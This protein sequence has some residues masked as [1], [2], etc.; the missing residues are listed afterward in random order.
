MASVKVAPKAP[1]AFE[2][3]PSKL[4]DDSFS[5]YLALVRE[6][7]PPELGNSTPERLSCRI[8]LGARRTFDGE[9]EIF[10][11]EKY[12]SGVMDSDA[13]PQ[14]PENG[15]EK[16]TKKEMR[17]RVRSRSRT[18]SISSE[19][20]SNSRSTL[21]RDR[22]KHPVPGRQREAEGK[23]FLG[24]FPC[25]CARKNAIDVDKEALSHARSDS[26]RKQVAQAG[27]RRDEHLVSDSRLK[28][29]GPGLRRQVFASGEARKGGGAPRVV[30]AADFFD[31]ASTHRR[32]LKIASGGEGGQDD[33]VQSEASSD[34]FEIESL[35]VTSSHPFITHEGTESVTT[36]TYEPSEASVDW[37]VVM[38]SVANF[39]I[40]SEPAAPAASLRK[41]RRS[42]GSGLLLGCVSEK[43]V[44]VTSGAKK[45]TEGTSFVHWERPGIDGAARF[46]AES[47]GVDVGSGSTG[48]VLPPSP[49]G[50]SRSSH[51]P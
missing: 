11:A 4:R 15:P 26:L 10:D 39:S 32:T 29:V 36:T 12:F 17:V 19:M 3:S 25:S 46:R 48:R 5:T 13:P 40:A 34:L 43:A 7:F 37:S 35:S 20:T 45:T 27:D 31:A 6:N 9:I 28:R 30:F 41:T 18:G 33:D 24:V 49:F 23:R 22:R 38:R 51:D 50:S 47:C 8:S 42:S 21:L 1:L 44:D 2:N 14:G 16:P